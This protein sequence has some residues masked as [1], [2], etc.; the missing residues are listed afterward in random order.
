M[1]TSDPGGGECLTV[2]SH[3]MI[4]TLDVSGRRVVLVTR[5]GVDVYQYKN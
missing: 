1:E 5:W 4:C 3:E 2:S